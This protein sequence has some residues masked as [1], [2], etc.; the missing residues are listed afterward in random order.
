[1]KFKE[2]ILSIIIALIVVTVPNF[3]AFA[4][5]V[6]D[7]KSLETIAES[8]IEIVNDNS[9]TVTYKNIEDFI[10]E[11]KKSISDISDIELS[12]F[13][14]DYTRQ[15]YEGLPDKIIL[16]TLNYK[17]IILADEYIMVSEKGD[18]ASI[19]QKKAERLIAKE[20]ARKAT[21]NKAW[22]S[23]NGY[24]KITTSASLIK[25]SGNKLYYQIATKC[26][27]LKPPLLF[28]KDVVALHHTGT[29]DDSY[30]VY[31][32]LYENVKCCTT[33]YNDRYE[34]K[35]GKSASNIKIEYP[36]VSV[37]NTRFKLVSTSGYTCTKQ[38]SQ[39]AKIINNIEAYLSYGIILK[40]DN[41]YNVQGA[42]CHKQISA[43]SIGV[44]VSAGGISFSM[45]IK[46]SKKDYNAKPI[47]VNT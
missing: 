7:T 9:G 33:T 39:H 6:N 42:Y 44:S 36:Q 47:T 8:T 34:T 4:L 32:Y 10:T 43:G 1:M 20:K 37:A 24:M 22:T 28:F 35:N 27:W 31:G 5:S 11:V 41:A 18:V 12:K 40:K 3:Q 16:N 29:F 30:E 23:D 19:S 13:I 38:V 14:L 21:S 45:S 25:K 2:K 46:G 26:N 15:D 17:E